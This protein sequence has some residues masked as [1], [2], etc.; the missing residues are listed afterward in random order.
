MNSENYLFLSYVYPTDLYIWG[1]YVCVH[2]YTHIYD[3]LYISL[4]SLYAYGHWGL[5]EFCLVWIGSGDKVTFYTIGRVSLIQELSQQ[6]DLLA[7]I[8]GIYGI[9]F[10]PCFQT[11]ELCQYIVPL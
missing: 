4:G 5:A 11:I 10:C 3:N 6:K 7:G 2:M 8:V 1:M 9:H